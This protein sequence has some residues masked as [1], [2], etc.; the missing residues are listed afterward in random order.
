VDIGILFENP[1]PEESSQSS[2]KHNLA[3]ARMLRKDI[4][5]ITLNNADE[6][7]LNQIFSKGHCIQINNPKHHALFKMTSYSKIAEFGYYK[8]KFEKSFTRKL[9]DAEEATDT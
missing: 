3:L 1:D 7:L 4:H 5:L 9:L 2:I 6:R 8:S